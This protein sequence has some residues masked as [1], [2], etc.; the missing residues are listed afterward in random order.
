MVDLPEHDSC[1]IVADCGGSDR[2]LLVEEAL[3]GT[4][5]F[6]AG[7]QQIWRTQFFP[8]WV[9]TDLDAVVDDFCAIIVFGCD[10]VLVL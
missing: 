7:M 4:G 6:D 8:A 9:L 2:V 3:P 5:G 1:V 10:E